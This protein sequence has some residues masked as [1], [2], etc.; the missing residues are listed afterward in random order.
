MEVGRNFP[1]LA[2]HERRPAHRV[3]CVPDFYRIGVVG[4]VFRADDLTNRVDARVGTTRTNSRNLAPE[5][6]RESGFELSLYRANI[7]LTRPATKGCAVVRDVQ[8]EV[9]LFSSPS[10]ASEEVSSPDAASGSSSSG[11]PVGPSSSSSPMASGV[12]SSS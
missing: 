1:A 10:S 9:Q 8:P 6:A 7:G 12:A 4:S 3:Q 2:H 11:S 5:Q